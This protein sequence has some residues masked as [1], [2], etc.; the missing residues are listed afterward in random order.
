MNPEEDGT[1]V[2]EV[3]ASTPENAETNVESQNEEEN[4]DEPDVNK[5]PPTGDTEPQVSERAAAAPIETSPLGSPR[6]Q[7]QTVCKD[8]ASGP[9]PGSDEERNR[10]RRHKNEPK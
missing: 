3:D 6:V 8:A 1:T 10:R 5:P 7:F 4:S 9:D 2:T